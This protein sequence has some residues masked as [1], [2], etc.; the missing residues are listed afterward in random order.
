MLDLYR[1]EHRRERG[2]PRRVDILGELR[3]RGQFRL[4]LG[5]PRG[6]RRALAFRAMAVAARIVGD[7]DEAAFGAALDMAAE[8]RRAARLDRRHDAA[9]GAA[10][11]TGMRLTVS[12]TVAAEDIRHLQTGHDRRRSGWTGFLQLKPV[13]RAGRVADRRGGN[14]RVA[15]RRRQVAMPE[16]HLDMGFGAGFEQVGGKAVAQVWTVTGLPSFAATEVR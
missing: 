7:A 12:L 13:E 2:D 8:P 16:Q 11:V 9:L 6:A 15:G 3:A 10:E 5:Q 1:D 4:A 14:L